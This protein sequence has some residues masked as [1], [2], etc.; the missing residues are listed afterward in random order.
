M[1]TGLLA[2]FK[3]KEISSGGW[4]PTYRT[5]TKPNGLA[6]GS[7]VKGLLDTQ[8]VLGAIL[9]TIKAWEEEEREGWTDG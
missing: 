9:S 5:K 8:D 1:E 6:I 3:E 2:A 4:I 7:V